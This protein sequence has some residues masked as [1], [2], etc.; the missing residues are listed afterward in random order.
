MKATYGGAAADGVAATATLIKSADDPAV[1]D[2]G[3]YFKDADGKA[4]RTLKALKTDAK[5]LLKL[6]KLYAD[7]T[8]GTF[9][10]RID[11]AGGA[12]LT[13]ELTVAAAETS[14]P[15]PSTSPSAGPGA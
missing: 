2:K 10:L 7:D 6:P 9:L 8:T 12:T 4:V 14:S 3:P 5:G 15:S 11:T 13:V 1:A